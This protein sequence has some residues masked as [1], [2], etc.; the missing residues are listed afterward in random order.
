MLSR[1]VK[2][3]NSWVMDTLKHEKKEE[4]MTKLLLGDY[5]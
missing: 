2:S 3:I 5:K 1:E 4:E